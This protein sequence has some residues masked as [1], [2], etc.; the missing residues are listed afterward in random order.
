M[1]MPKHTAGQS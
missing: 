1:T